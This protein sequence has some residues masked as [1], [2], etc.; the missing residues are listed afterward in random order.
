MA[1]TG[2]YGNLGLG[3]NSAT[4][5]DV[6][7]QNGSDEI[8]F[9]DEAND[10][11]SSA[12]PES[13]LMR[14]KVI[15]AT[16]SSLTVFTRFIKDQWPSGDDNMAL[17]VLEL[18][19]KYAGGFC[20]EMQILDLST[21]SHVRLDLGKTLGLLRNKTGSCG[22]KKLKKFVL[23][24]IKILESGDILG[25][26]C[27]GYCRALCSTTETVID[28]LCLHCDEI[29]DSFVAGDLQWI[30][31]LRGLYQMS[32]INVSYMCVVFTKLIYI[33]IL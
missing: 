19:L 17:E 6:P 7:I 13:N 4:P 11:G 2:T 10:G 31:E 30:K 9:S 23:P 5:R 1:E 25:K 33:H 22:I 16:K 14:N 12:E 29:S 28:Q 32:Q 21:T 15:N 18:Q 3:F 26:V 20:T 24:N 27:R 8:H